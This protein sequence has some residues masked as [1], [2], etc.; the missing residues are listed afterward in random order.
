M[1]MNFGSFSFVD[2]GAG[3][4]DLMATIFPFQVNI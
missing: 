2:F 1:D 4:I 3:G